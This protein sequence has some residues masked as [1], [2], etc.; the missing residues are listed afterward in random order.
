M[1]NII[2]V[3]SAGEGL[4]WFAISNCLRYGREKQSLKGEQT[5][6]VECTY[7]KKGEAR[8]AVARVTLAIVVY[9]TPTESIAQP[10][11]VFGDGSGSQ[12]MNGWRGIVAC[13]KKL[14]LMVPS[15][16]SSRG[17]E[18]LGT[19]EFK[20][21]RKG[22][23][24]RA[25]SSNNDDRM[26]FNLPNKIERCQLH[27]RTLEPDKAARYSS[28]YNS[29]G[30]AEE[31]SLKGEQTCGVEC[32]YPKKGE[33]RRAVARVTLA[34]VVY[35]T[36]TES[37]AQPFLVFGDGS[38]SQTMNGWRGIA[39]K[40]TCPGS[41]LLKEATFKGRLPGMFKWK[42]IEPTKQAYRVIKKGDYSTIGEYL[43]C[44]CRKMDFSGN[45]A[46]LG[47]TISNHHHLAVEVLAHECARKS[48]ER[49]Q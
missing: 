31:Q 14:L 27:L 10:F 8:R 5:C 28:S 6:G 40:I 4:L 44:E 11:L 23:G 45:R 16:P 18:I 25:A 30:V 15:T 42:P 2:R 41:G 35:Q 26:P 46:S 43:F 36:P 29:S 38:G 47:P 22:S 17:S 7:P 20:N 1:Q 32:T 24:L 19:F 33:A 34:I 3:L 49:H 48:D 39:R 37:I 21:G 13:L 12:T 9:Q